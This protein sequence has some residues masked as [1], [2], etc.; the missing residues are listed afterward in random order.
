MKHFFNNLERNICAICLLIMLAI[1]S[2]QVF[3]RFF[4]VSNSWSE[5]LARY[6]FI[7][8]IFV[9]SGL[10]AEKHAHITIETMTY[11]W[12]KKIRRYVEILGCLVWVAFALVIVYYSAQYTNMLYHANRISLSLYVNMAYPY[13]AIPV[14]YAF[15]A[16]RIVQR[17]L[18]PRLTNRTKELSLEEKV[19]ASVE[20]GE[21]DE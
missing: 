2:V 18:I 9:G 4:G 11:I 3:S 19:L 7:W 6:L 21:A 1:L 15:L 10:A 17:E 13:A 14:G 20:E 16:V 5:E 12:P 8:L